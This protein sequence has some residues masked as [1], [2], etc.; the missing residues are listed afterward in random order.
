M[1]ASSSDLSHNNANQTSKGL[2]LNMIIFIAIMVHK[3][4]AAFGLVTVLMSEGCSRALVRKILLAFSLAAPFGALATW[5]GLALI[6]RIQLRSAWED[7]DDEKAAEM[8]WWIGMT[9]L[10]SGGTFL[11]VATHTLQRTPSSP[12]DSCCIPIN[13]NQRSTNQLSQEESPT[14]QIEDDQSKRKAFIGPLSTSVL[15]VTGMLVPWL[16]TS[17]VGGHHHD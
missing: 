5:A 9:L 13:F 4:P 16:L 1:G 10:F 17:L 14:H 15:M 11:F 8:Q 7:L 2:S 12:I 3:A 6:H